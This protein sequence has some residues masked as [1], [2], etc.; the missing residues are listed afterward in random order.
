M[1]LTVPAKI[2]EASGEKAIANFNGE[3]REV[4]TKFVRA[5]KGDFV[6]CAGGIVMERITEK[7]A[8]EMLEIFNA[9]KR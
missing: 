1:C 9:D 7:R 8:M 3:L 5:E 4:S 2:I 6:I